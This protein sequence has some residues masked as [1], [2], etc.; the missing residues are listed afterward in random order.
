MAE[1]LAGLTDEELVGRA[2]GGDDQSIE[3]LIARYRHYAWAKA[4]TYFLVGADRED[5]V[6]EGMI[7]L[8]KAIRDFQVEKQT[9]FR[10]FAELCIT[11]Q[12][13]SAI[14][15]ATCQKHLP[16]NTYVSLSNLI[17]AGDPSIRENGAK[18]EASDPADVVISWEEV[19]MIRSCMGEALSH[20][21]T[22][23]L[24]LFMEGKSYQQMAEQLGR[25]AKSIDNALQRIRRK[26][27]RHIAEREASALAEGV[28]T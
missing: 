1:E 14:K 12:I 22:I 8:Y 6:Q 3:A 19:A 21:E 18:R 5:L 23:V 2:Q 17:G 7:G 4:R 15:S 20:L 26:L 28:E 9:A 16:L 11:R 27:E 13:L 24:Q 10:A 25:H